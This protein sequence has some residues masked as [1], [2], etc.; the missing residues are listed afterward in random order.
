MTDQ[1]LTNA[2]HQ[3]NVLMEAIHQTALDIG[4]CNKDIP[5]TGPHLLMFCQDF[6]S[7]IKDQEAKISALERQ[8]VDMENELNV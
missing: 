4:L 1:I 6:T 5:P 8:L 7:I 2:E 3:R